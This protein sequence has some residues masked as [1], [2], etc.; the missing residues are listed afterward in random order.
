M[1]WDNHKKKYKCSCDIRVFCPIK[2]KSIRLDHSIYS[3]DMACEI[4]KWECYD[5][6]NDLINPDIY[7]KTYI[8]NPEMFAKTLWTLVYF[9]KEALNNKQKC[10]QHAEVYVSRDNYIKEQWKNWYLKSGDLYYNV[11]T[12]NRDTEICTFYPTQFTSNI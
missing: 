6:L 3:H 8:I 11:S 7:E 1:S 4:V 5:K 10:I 9:E 2:N 12:K